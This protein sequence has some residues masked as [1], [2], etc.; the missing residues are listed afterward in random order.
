ML[1][2]FIIAAFTAVALAWI[3]LHMLLTFTWHD[4]AQRSTGPLW[5]PPV[6]RGRCQRTRA[7]RT[8]FDDILLSPLLWEQADLIRA[9][10]TAPVVRLP[11]GATFGQPMARAAA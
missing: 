5:V 6:Y 3:G 1:F 2:G 4:P 11:V 10:W 8:R 9:Q 7:P